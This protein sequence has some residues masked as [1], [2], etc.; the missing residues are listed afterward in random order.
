[1]NTCTVWC[2]IAITCLL[3]AARCWTCNMCIWLS[4]CF[5][6]ANTKLFICPR[7]GRCWTYTK[8]CWTEHARCA[9]TGLCWT[10][11][12]SCA[13][14]GLCWTKHATWCHTG[15]DGTKHAACNGTRL[16]SPKHATCGGT[17]Q[18]PTTTPCCATFVINVLHVVF[19]IFEHGCQVDVR[20]WGDVRLNPGDYTLVQCLDLLQVRRV[21]FTTTICITRTCFRWILDGCC[22]GD[23]VKLW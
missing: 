3:S 14:S 16:D 4:C 10:E 8:L 17:R 21:I 1:M 22:V 13:N 19:I 18:W 7:T 11:H 5:I 9:Y 20:V 6:R 2:Y 12:A 15:L 23:N